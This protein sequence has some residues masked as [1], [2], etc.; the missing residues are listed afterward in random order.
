VT[1]QALS[2]IQVHASEEL[3][4]VID[5]EAL[6][7][8][9]IAAV[10]YAIFLVRLLHHVPTLFVLLRH[11]PCLQEC[12]VRFTHFDAAFC[13]FVGSHAGLKKSSTTFQLPVRAITVCIAITL[14]RSTQTCWIQELSLLNITSL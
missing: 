6:V 3:T 14:C 11:C 2:H 12:V 13:S 1:I 4:T 10:L 8:D 9:G 5:G 7:D